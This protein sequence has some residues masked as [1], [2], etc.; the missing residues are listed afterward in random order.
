MRRRLF[1]FLVLSIGAAAALSLYRLLGL[2]IL[3]PWRRGAPATTPATA[4]SPASMGVG[5][6]VCLPLPR[7]RGNVSL[8]EAL[9]RRRSVRDYTSMPV[10]LEELSQ[11]LWAAYGVT[12]INWS[13][14]T[15]PSAG[16]TYPLD[17]YVVVRSGGVSMISGG[18]LAPGSYRYDFRSHCL[19]LVREGDFSGQLSEAALA[20]T[21]VREAALNIVIFGVY[22]R[23]TRRYGERGYRYVYMEAGHASQNIYLQAT[24][25]GLGTVSVGAFYDDR[26]KRIVGAVEGEPLY[27]MPVGR[28]VSLYDLREEELRRYY[29]KNR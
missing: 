29:E 10:S 18:F 28:P 3:R 9:R 25:L 15:T 27:I 26:V 8:E 21:W 13:L 20:Q 16:G 11:L 1:I 14:K 7:L 4:A 17:I 12:E 2:D 24:A 22:E 23:T 19:E 5:E 6:R